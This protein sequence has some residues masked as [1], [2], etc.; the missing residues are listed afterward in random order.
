MRTSLWLRF[1]LL[2]AVLLGTGATA[3]ASIVQALGLA[4][5][6]RQADHVVVARVL[7][8]QV[9]L[10]EKGRI[11]TDVQMQ[12]EDAAKGRHAPGASVVVRKL[13]GILDGIGMRIEGEPSYEDG[14]TVLLFAAQRLPSAVL[15]PVG[16]SQGKMPIFEQAGVRWVKSAPVGVSLVRKGASGLEP[17]PAALTE[18]RRLE[19]V[20]S[21][22][23][24]HVA[25]QKSA[26]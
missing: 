6:V 26:P 2:A 14:E 24:E 17:Q 21:E 18:P 13:G 12:V 23:R 1:L 7:S 10:D 25:K 20:L 22:I 11:V 9:H 16:L 19:E 3:R 15:R 8:Q 4:E 5:L